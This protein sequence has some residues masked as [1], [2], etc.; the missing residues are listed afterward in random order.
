METSLSWEEI[1]ALRSPEKIL[2]PEDKRR[3]AERLR[4]QASRA[5]KKLREAAEGEPILAEWLKT[6]A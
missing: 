4:Q 2:T 6:L 3:E 1:A 5:L